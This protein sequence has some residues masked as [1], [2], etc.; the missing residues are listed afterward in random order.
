M[1]GTI[2]DIQKFSIHDGP[3]IRT[4]V[5]LKGCP[6]RCRW[7][8]NPESNSRKPQLSF[9]PERCIGCGFCFER[10]P[11]H[12]HRMVDGKHAH[13]RSLCRE[14]GACTEKCYAEALEMIGREE[15]VEDVLAEVLK[16]K[17]FYETSGGGMTLSGGEPLM[18]ID[19]SEELLRQAKAAGLHCAL[20]TSGFAPF[21]HLERLLPFV[22]LWLYDI[23][24]VD[25]TLHRE[26][27]GVSNERILA[28]VRELHR[29]GV[30]L[31]LRLPLVPGYNDRDEDLQALAALARELPATLGVE[32]MPYHRLGEG[33]L[34]R[35]GMTDAVRA[36]AE[37]PEPSMVNAWIDRLAE[38]GA[39]V[40]NER[41]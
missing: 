7:C 34:D 31:L 27:T 14:C 22:D 11:N 3:G 10:C 16:D 35:L 26:L 5:F 37:S 17:P 20:E 13:D 29:R 32:I 36:V 33:K 4:T 38:L 30:A 8:H 1:T 6:L 12:A 24:A 23:K 41:R 21:D 25:D 40:I 19:F 18:Q 15:S 9:M 2:F 39:R 28:N